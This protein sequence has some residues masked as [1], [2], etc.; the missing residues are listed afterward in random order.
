MGAQTRFP[1]P[2]PAYTNPNIEPQFFQ[3]SV[4]PIASISYGTSTTV[5]TGTSFGVSNNYVVGQLVRFLIPPTYGAQQLNNQQGYVTSIPGPNQVTVGINT[6]VGYSSFVPSPP[7][8]PTKPQILAI[9]DINTGNIGNSGRTNVPL[10]IPGSFIN[11][12]PL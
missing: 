2:T 7:Y 6:S 8:G 5:T 3:P 11:I 4:F 1:G 10:V 9:G 12:S